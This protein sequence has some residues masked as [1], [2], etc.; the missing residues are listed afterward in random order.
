[1]VIQRLSQTPELCP[2]AELG[3]QHGADSPGPEQR[4]LERRVLDQHLQ[5]PIVMKQVE[6][7]EGQLVV[8]I[9]C[10]VVVDVF[11]SNAPL[12]K[13][14]HTLNQV[15]TRAWV[16]TIPDVERSRQNSRLQSELGDSELD[17]SGSDRWSRRRDCQSWIRP[18]VKNHEQKRAA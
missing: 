6:A 5:P 1:M 3:D 16:M 11:V 14:V 4:Q 2:T 15:L 18:D 9:S 12:W 8:H 17:A 10:H 7:T 13:V